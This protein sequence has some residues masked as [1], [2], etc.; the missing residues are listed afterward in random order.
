MVGFCI[1]IGA[2]LLRGVGRGSGVYLNG[3]RVESASGS[4]WYVFG[5]A[6]AAVDGWSLH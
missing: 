5:R 3:L 1:R 2:R 6:F 4:A